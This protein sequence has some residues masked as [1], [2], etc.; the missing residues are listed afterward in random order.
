MSSPRNA[1]I[2]VVSA[3]CLM[4][5]AGVIFLLLVVP[6]MR[7]GAPASMAQDE[8]AEGAGPPGPPGPEAGPPGPPGAEAGPPGP[9]MGPDMGPMGPGG[10]DMGAAGGAAPAAPK[11]ELPPTEPSS[12][13]P[14]TGAGVVSQGDQVT[15]DELH[16]TS[17]GNDWSRIP[18]TVQ[19]GFPAPEVPERAAPAAP[20][21]ALGTDKPLRIT[22]IMWTKDG[23]ALAVYEYGEGDE[24]E[25]GTVRPGD[26]VATWQVV[27]I[28]QDLVIVEDRAS[29]ARTEVYLAH[30][31]PKPEKKVTPPTSGQ[32]GRQPRSDGRQ[33]QPGRLGGPRQP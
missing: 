11:R 14:F 21:S 24:M 22:S 28:R 5:L 12:A 9:G 4:A 20:P 10:P 23:Q 3:V 32:G 1:K 25:S 13:N 33:R 26:R 15:I 31:A 27:E 6:T 30:R 29:K 7:G 2:M 19:K 17:Y 8:G 18:I 16:Y